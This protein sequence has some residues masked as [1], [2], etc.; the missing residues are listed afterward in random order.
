MP[1]FQPAKTTP[2]EIKFQSSFLQEM[3]RK[4]WVV[5]KFSFDSKLSKKRIFEIIWSLMTI[6]PTSAQVGK[7]FLMLI[8]SI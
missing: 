7:T 6:L 1:L 2:K 8:A 4:Y 3:K 5:I